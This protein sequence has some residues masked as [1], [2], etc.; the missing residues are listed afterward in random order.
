M[1]EK[2]YEESTRHAKG[3]FLSR[4]FSL[5]HC[6]NFSSQLLSRIDHRLQ[7]ARCDGVAN[8]INGFETGP[9]IMKQGVVWAAH[10]RQDNRVCGNGPP[11]A[12]PNIVDFELMS[13]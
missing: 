12:T 9:E 3:K 6:L 10:H 5:F 13:V 7:L 11:L 4:P 2:N 1:G 8:A